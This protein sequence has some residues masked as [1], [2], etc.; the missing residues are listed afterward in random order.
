MQI[1]VQ[2][3]DSQFCSPLGFPVVSPSMI[4]NTTSNSGGQHKCL[5]SLP[6]WSLQDLKG[7]V[8]SWRYHLRVLQGPELLGTDWQRPALFFPWGSLHFPGLGYPLCLIIFSLWHLWRQL[9][10]GPLHCS[11]SINRLFLRRETCSFLW[12]PVFPTSYPNSFICK[13]T[14][15]YK[16]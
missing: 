7:S 2:A 13:N 1:R 9:A 8:P 14:P 4:L 15:R 16:R 12:E 6:P 10:E 3:V 11:L 5:Y